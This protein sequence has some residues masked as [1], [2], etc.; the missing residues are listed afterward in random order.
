M[1]DGGDIGVAIA[2]ADDMTACDLGLGL[3]DIAALTLKLV[4]VEL[5]VRVDIPLSTTA[6]DVAVALE[7]SS[8]PA[9]ALPPS[10]AS[11]LPAPTMLL[12]LPLTPSRSPRSVPHAAPY[13]TPIAVADARRHSL[14]PLMLARPKT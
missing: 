3:A 1:V 11:P 7:G 10:L 12:Q 6:T 8:L 2:P 13:T 4:P 5:P 14:L 9:P